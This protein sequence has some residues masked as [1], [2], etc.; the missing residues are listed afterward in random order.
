MK[1]IYLEFPKFILS[2]LMLALFIAPLQ[3]ETVAYVSDSLTIPMRSGT[4]NRHKILKFL[5]SGTQLKIQQTSEDGSYV[6][7]ITPEDKEGWVEVAHIMDQPS[8]REQ[9]IVLNKKLDDMQSKISNLK[10][11]LSEN[12]NLLKQYENQ[13]TT[14]DEQNKAL[15]RELSTLKKTASNPIAVAEKNKSLEN[16]IT[17][18]SNK[19]EQLMQENARLNDN[20]IKEW[21]MIGAAVSLGSLFL[22]LIIPRISWRKKE[23]WGSNF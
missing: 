15:R 11:S 21:F 8:A 20:S 2:F 13:N 6:K 14:L 10:T 7:V 22:G 18:I 19:N 17:D 4:T 16:Q 1:I 9:M 3:A 12:K 5:P 23:S